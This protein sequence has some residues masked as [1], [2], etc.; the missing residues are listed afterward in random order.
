ML[1]DSTSSAEMMN[2][3]LGVPF[4]QEALNQANPIRPVTKIVGK[5]GIGNDSSRHDAAV[6]QL[7][8]PGKSPLNLV[9]VV[10]DHSTKPKG[11]SSRS[12]FMTA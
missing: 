11:I 3:I 12:R 2:D 9:A 1:V 4:M 8:R 6:V 10:L 7:D 5:V